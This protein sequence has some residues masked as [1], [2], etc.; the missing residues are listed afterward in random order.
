MMLGLLVS[1]QNGWFESM[2]YFCIDHAISCAAMKP[3]LSFCVGHTAL[4]LARAWCAERRRGE[5]LQRA[6]K[7]PPVVLGTC[8]AQ[9][10][11][12]ILC[13]RSGIILEGKHVI[14]SACSNDDVGEVV[15]AW[16]YL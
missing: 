10:H 6:P 7:K 16:G 5:G 13:P 9:S 15:T 8:Q 11:F 1:A 4:C 3:A 2:S 12:A 14:A